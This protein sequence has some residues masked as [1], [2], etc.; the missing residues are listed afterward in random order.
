[1]NP[2]LPRKESKIAP[3]YPIKIDPTLTIQGSGSDTEL[4]ELLKNTNF[5]SGT[6][7]TLDGRV[8]LRNVGLILMS[9]GD[10]PAGA[11][12]STATFSTYWYNT[13][14]GETV[15]LYRLRRADWVEAEATWNIYKTG[16]N[17]GTAGALNTTTDHDTTV[18]ASGTLPAS[19]NNWMAI[20]VKSIVEHAVANSL[21][22]NVLM[23]QTS[24]GGTNQFC[25]S[26]EYAT[27]TS[28]RPKLVIE[29][30]VAANNFFII[31]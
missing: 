1:M 22:F 30:T 6:S 10:L 11:V 5:G 19:N 20:N 28:L 16:S 2:L 4:S 24:G 13:E 31:F 17:W 15:A 3:T 27:N 18:T 25:Y 14:S 21:A 23:I 9:L 12:I 8:G 7:I 29:Y 26:K